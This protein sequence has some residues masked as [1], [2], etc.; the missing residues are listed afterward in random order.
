M[1]LDESLSPKIKKFSVLP[2][3]LAGRGNC[4]WGR[5]GRRLTATKTTIRQGQVD[6]HA[7]GGRWTGRT[8]SVS[9]PLPAVLR[10]LLRPNE[11]RFLLEQLAST[12]VGINWRLS[13]GRSTLA[14]HRSTA[15]SAHGAVRPTLFSPIRFTTTTSRFLRHK[16][17]AS[18]ASSSL[19]LAQNRFVSRA[20][21]SVIPFHSDL[22]PL[23][24]RE[25][26]RLGGEGAVHR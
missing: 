4:R 25:A 20:I 16:A 26:R 14:G 13:K 21:S 19:V 3:S 12:T 8:P 10:Q 17:A 23:R 18:L 24:D 7:G 6:T 11:T 1:F 15:R 22:Y 5:G 9:L 2:A